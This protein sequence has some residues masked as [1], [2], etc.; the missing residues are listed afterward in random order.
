MHSDGN[1][2]V[3]PCRCPANSLKCKPCGDDYKQRRLD[4]SYSK[5]IAAGC[6]YRAASSENKCIKPRRTFLAPVV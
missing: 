1:D 2:T 6:C 3:N 5:C 4:K